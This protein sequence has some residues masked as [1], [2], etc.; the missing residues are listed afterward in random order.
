MVSVA[1]FAPL[2]DAGGAFFCLEVFPIFIKF[3]GGAVF[4]YSGGTSDFFK[5][6]SWLRNSVYTKSPWS[7][8]IW[9]GGGRVGF[10]PQGIRCQG[11]L[12]TPRGI[13]DASVGNVLADSVYLAR[14]RG[15]SFGSYL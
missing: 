4:L 8:S 14:L 9:L 1:I 7:P 5:I 10:S 15:F 13:L 2:V 11:Y 12:A 6:E 3:Y